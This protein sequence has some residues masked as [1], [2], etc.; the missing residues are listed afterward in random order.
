LDFRDSKGAIIRPTGHVEQQFGDRYNTYIQQ[1]EKFPV[2]HQIPSPPKS[3]I[4]REE[5]IEQ[6][7]TGFNQGCTIVGLGG[8]GGLGKTALAYKLAELLRDRYK[9]G[10]LM[11]NPLGI[12]PT[13]TWATWAWNTKRRAISSA[14]PV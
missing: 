2:P 14:P 4:G 13:P 12:S 7:L 10:Q 3:F 9:D 11:V 8:I 1:T 6:I 5:L